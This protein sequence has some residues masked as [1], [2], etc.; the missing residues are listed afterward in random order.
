MKAFQILG[1]NISFTD[2]EEQFFN[3]ITSDTLKLRKKV[4]LPSNSVRC[5]MITRFIYIQQ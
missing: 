2:Q 4:I 5:L 1:H 3:T